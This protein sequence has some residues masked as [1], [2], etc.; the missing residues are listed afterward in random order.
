MTACALLLAGAVAGVAANGRP[1]EEGE[2]VVTEGVGPYQVCDPVFE[3]VRIAMTQRGEAWSPQY[4]Q[5]ISGSAFRVTGPCP[6][7]PTCGNW[8]WAPDL[9]KLLGYDCEYLLLGEE[10]MAP[11]VRVEEVLTRIKDEIRAGRT[12]ILWHAF[13]NAEF[14]VVCGFDEST[15]ELLGRGSYKGLGDEYT[16]ADEKRTLTSEEISGLL[17]A[18]IIGEK[19][20]E[21]DAR[22][23]ETAALKEAVNHCWAEKSS[24]LKGGVNCYDG[25]IGDLSKSPPRELGS[26]DWY[27]L[28]VYSSTHAAAPGFLREI[29]PKYGGA[30][31][32]LEH[33]ADHFVQEADLLHR[34]FV[35]LGE[36]RP[37]DEP[38]KVK[39]GQM[40][41]LLRQ[42]RDAYRHGIHDIER[43]LDKIEGE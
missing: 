34:C 21:F 24:F 3:S 27:C 23:A 28:A 19:E 32:N 25:W 2:R 17:G 18:I 30:S 29:A 15:H 14:D 31:R 38:Q 12:A 40:A 1:A 16:R 37:A 43:A 33:A 20:R 13:T 6:C 36:E 35:V 7:A 8:F 26:G 9:V 11:Q 4:I 10:G 42:A 41:D 5:G 22:A 39:A